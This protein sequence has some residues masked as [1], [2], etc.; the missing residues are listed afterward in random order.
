MSGN[1]PPKDPGSPSGAALLLPLGQPSRR[2]SLVSSS[3]LSHIDKETLSQTLDHIHSA[4]SQSES[5]TT[6]NEYTAPP[7]VSE[8]GEGRGITTELQGGLS[9]LYNRLRASVGGARDTVGAGPGPDEDEGADNGSIQS[10]RSAT[11]S[12][13]PST[14]Q[15]FSS[16]RLSAPGPSSGTDTGPSTALQ[17]PRIA[18]SEMS[19]NDLGPSSK[20]SRI[21]T[22]TSS[23]TS[24]PAT[25]VMKPPLTPLTPTAPIILSS[26]AVVEVNVTAIKDVEPRP[27]Q[28][29]TLSRASTINK[30]P[31]KTGPSLRVDEH[32]SG[33]A[34]NSEVDGQK[35]EPAIHS[36][37]GSYSVS[38]YTPE[39][40]TVTSENARIP[41]VSAVKHTST[42]GQPGGRLEDHSVMGNNS[43]HVQEPDRA[44]AS[45]LFN[46]RTSSGARNIAEVAS[47]LETPNRPT[48]ANERRQTTMSS[49]SASV[50]E[51]SG[52]KNNI[53]GTSTVKAGT[54][55]RVAQSHLPGFSLSRASSSD[56]V[57]TSSVN[58][59][60]YQK[61]SNGAP[62]ED[63]V[64]R[65]QGMSQ[66]RKP[67][68]QDGERPNVNIPLSQTRSRVLSKEYWMRDENARDCFYCG[69]SFSTFRRKHHCRKSLSKYRF[70]KHVSRVLVMLT[71]DGQGRVVRFSMANA[72]L[73]LPGN[74]LVNLAHYVCAN[75]AKPSSMDTMIPLSIPRTE[76][77][78]TF[79]LG[80]DMGQRAQAN[81]PLFRTHRNQLL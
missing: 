6:F 39:A 40:L 26:P 22:A 27:R 21:P 15:P 47:G 24:L 36:H 43:T 7:S 31:P 80:Q 13:T 67:A 25:G 29:D 3:A 72:L 75:H 45:N 8:G 70:L 44:D 66:V 60:M 2:A 16:N 59:T 37:S 4:A 19:I 81:F 50:A 58:T 65:K 9:G 41:G 17:S 54:A 69:D 52:S 5:L 28:E 38:S 1:K 33:A 79:H 23:R 48:N 10:P 71:K 32:V 76:V 73:W 51:V 78:Q 64:L 62:S 20:V 34:D 68:R 42:S 77:S 49:L 14:K 12:S 57:G 30:V 18:G 61:S 35:K 55:Q 11:P 74:S 53:N 63:E 56:T 46:T